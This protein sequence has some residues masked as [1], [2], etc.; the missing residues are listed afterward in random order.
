MNA[1]PRIG[2]V[3][4]Y[5]PRACGIAT[6][7]RDLT[8]AMLI[9]GQV[10]RTLVV[11]IEDNGTRYPA[12]ITRTIDQHDRASYI[13]TAEFLNESDIDLVSLQHEFGIFGGEW[14]EYVLDLCR[15]IDLPLVT[16]FHTVLRNPSEKVRQIVREIS[17]IS[18]AVVVTIASAAEILER[19]F[20]VDPEKIVVIHHG[21]E[22]PDCVRKEY[23]KRQLKIPD[24]TV[25]ATYGLISSGKGIEFAIKSLP[26]LVR[27]TPDILYVVMGETHPEVLK[28]EGE[29]YRDK[30]TSLA[31]NLGVNRN[32][33]FVNHYLRDD[34]LSLYLQATDIY[35][36]PYLGRD[37]VSSGTITLALAY[38]KA[39]V[40]TPTIFAKEILG[41]KRGLFCEFADAKSIAD[42]VKRILNGSRLRQELEANAAKYGQAIGWKGVADQYGDIFRSAISTQRTVAQVAAVTEF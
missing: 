34:E 2:C 32:V 26:Y 3:S 21:A 18:K 31:K 14:G 7:A 42:C 4:T 37:Q 36:A 9:G 19:H 16:T 39:I 17:Q 5:P 11:P 28:H 12:S 10:E 29:A 22:L 40:S 38:G 33:R 15:N 24:R 8:R 1:Q 25:L 6:F 30:L 41:H 13:S 27:K 35:V 23:A 20:G